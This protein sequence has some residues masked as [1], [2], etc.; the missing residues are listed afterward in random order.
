MGAHRR[1]NEE[2][3]R[4]AKDRFRPGAE[5][6][7]VVVSSVPFGLLVSLPDS[8]VIGVVLT[9]GFPSQSAFDR[10]NESHPAGSTIDA[11][12][13]GPAEGRMQIDLQ[14]DG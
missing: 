11:V 5:V 13:V 9:T 3:W 12:V 7:G 2:E 6:R 4:S 10:R 1:P 8:P 14:L